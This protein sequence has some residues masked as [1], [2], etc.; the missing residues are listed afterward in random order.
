VS[1][2]STI[3]YFLYNETNTS[4]HF[5]MGPLIQFDKVMYQ[6]RVV[7]RRVNLP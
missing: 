3:D 5:Q 1:R 4:D 6:A 7:S 2:V